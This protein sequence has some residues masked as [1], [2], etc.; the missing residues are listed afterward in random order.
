MVSHQVAAGNLCL[1]LPVSPDD[2]AAGFSAVTS[3]CGTRLLGHS[4]I[5]CH[6][7]LGETTG[8][9]RDA[10]RSASDSK[11]SHSMIGRLR[12]VSVI[13]QEALSFST[14]GY[15]VRNWKS[16]TLQKAWLQYKWGSPRNG[17]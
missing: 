14:L 7:S 11:Y 3:H 1:S 9:K 16:L 5:L 6:Q 4:A 10:F 8:E 12:V 2:L 17:L 13:S 15:I